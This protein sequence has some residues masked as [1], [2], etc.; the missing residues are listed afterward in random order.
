MPQRYLIWALMLFVTAVAASAQ[1]TLRPVLSSYTVMAG[2][3]HRADTYLTPLKNRG[4][5]VGVDYQRWQVA[6]WG[7]EQWVNNLELSL[8]AS[9]TGRVKGVYSMWGAD[10]NALFASMKRWPL[11]PALTVGTGPSA[12]IMAG[13][14]YRSRN[15]N[16]PVAAR[17]RITAGVQAY[18]SLNLKVGQLPVNLLYKANLP[19]A[20]AFFAPDYGQLYYEIYMG[21]TSGLV[22]PAVWG[23]FFALDQQLTIDLRF[24][25]TSLRL[26]YGVDISLTKAHDIV[27]RNITHNALVGISCEWLSL[28][29]GN[30]PDP[31]ARLLHAVY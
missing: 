13:A 5:N 11:T 4:W 1:P 19:V 21:D 10:V 8:Q 9:H 30:V 17:A 27:S 2:S 12:Q 31:D 28:S 24:G 26:G 22:A 3:A 6:R 14:L 23:P 15:G 25:A 29:P 20:G 7:G 18:A 16:N